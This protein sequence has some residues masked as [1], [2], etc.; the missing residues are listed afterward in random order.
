MC[1]SRSLIHTVCK[2]IRSERG[3]KREFVS[4]NVETPGFDASSDSITVQDLL[5]GYK[6]NITEIKALLCDKKERGC[7][8][9]EF[10]NEKVEEEKILELTYDFI[11]RPLTK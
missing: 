6:Q 3:E 5:N 10:N 1:A 11:T 2:Y 7:N 9:R 4:D 8:F